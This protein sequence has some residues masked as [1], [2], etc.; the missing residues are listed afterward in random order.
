MLL[1]AAGVTVSD[2]FVNAG[3]P[4]PFTLKLFPTLIVRLVTPAMSSVPVTDV[5]AIR[6][7]VAA[8]MSVVVEVSLASVIVVPRARSVT[9]LPALLTSPAIE[10]EPPINST[11]ST[12][13]MLL[14]PTISSAV[15]S[16]RPMVIRLNPFARAAM[17]AVD[18]LSVPAP[19]L[20]PIVVPAAPGLNVTVPVPITL[21]APPVRS[22]WSATSVRL[23]P[24]ML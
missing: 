2:R 11:L 7:T 19:S 21:L 12:N 20:S 3:D 15:A 9:A 17:S 13:V 14:V 10:I 22:I 1:T 5:A 4:T 8:V 23:P 24:P 18:R 6:V 16:V